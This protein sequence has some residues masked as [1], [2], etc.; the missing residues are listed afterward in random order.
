[1]KNTW[2]SYFSKVWVFGATCQAAGGVNPSHLWWSFLLFHV[3]QGSK[4]ASVVLFRKM[5]FW[6]FVCNSLEKTQSHIFNK[7]S[8]DCINW[9][10]PARYSRTFY[11]FSWEK[12]T[13]GSSFRL[14]LLHYS[15][16]FG[17]DVNF[18]CLADFR[19]LY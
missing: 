17:F 14:R 8:R 6:N 16:Q 2:K 5:T 3:W 1:M 7:I 12:K 10:R 9:Q 13:R 15:Q 11:E 19:K 4:Y 18:S